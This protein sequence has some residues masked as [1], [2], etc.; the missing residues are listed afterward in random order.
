MA[1]PPHAVSP[2]GS[3]SPGRAFSLSFCPRAASSAATASYC[4][5]TGSGDWSAGSGVFWL[6]S[7]RKLR[8]IGPTRFSL[9]TERLHGLW[10]RHTP[11]K[12]LW[13]RAGG[14]SSSDLVSSPVWSPWW[15]PSPPQHYQP[16]PPPP[17]P[18]QSRMP[19]SHS[20][21]AE[22]LPPLRPPR[23]ASSQPLPEEPVFDHSMR[24]GSH[25]SVGSYYPLAPSRSYHHGP[26]GPDTHPPLHPISTD[27]MMPS[28]Q[29]PSQSYVTSPQQGYGSQILSPTYGNPMMGGQIGQSPPGTPL[30][31]PGSAHR[32]RSTPSG[33][34]DAGSNKYRKLQPAP[35]PA[36][37]AGWSKQ[38]LKTIPYDV[39]EM[40]SSAALPNSGP[41]Q[42]R[43]WNVNQH[44]KR[45]K[46]DRQERTE[47]GNERDD[48]R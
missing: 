26:A 39:K 47:P 24:H 34:S 18:Q 21:S 41:T 7:A 42:I 40:G 43:G 10:I 16:P 28:P 31:P 30:G 33:S 44:R 12:W 2:C 45:G 1:Q 37:R 38:E 46:S 13:A 4:A 32:H 29:Q 11:P 23:A 48:S 5:A 19:F 20:A 25:G 3:R 8:L 6:H 22:P 14:L 9:G 15:S 17:P 27:R 35:V 36:H